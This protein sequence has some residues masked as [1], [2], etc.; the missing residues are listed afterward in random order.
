MNQFASKAILFDKLYPIILK[1]LI[2]NVKTPVSHYYDKNNLQDI[3]Y[4]WKKERKK[5]GTIFS[6]RC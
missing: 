3:K 2:G 1:N 5:S 6:E 4:V